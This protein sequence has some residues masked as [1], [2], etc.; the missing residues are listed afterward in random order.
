MREKERKG[1]LRCHVE[2][3]DAAAH[4]GLVK[5]ERMVDRQWESL[6]GLQYI[7]HCQFISKAEA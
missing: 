4:V 1:L 6:I 3:R 7:A 2:E 5:C